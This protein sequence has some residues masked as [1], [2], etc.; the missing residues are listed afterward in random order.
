MQTGENQTAQPP[1]NGATWRSRRRGGVSSMHFEL[2]FEEKPMEFL[3]GTRTELAQGQVGH[4]Q[5][6][7]YSAFSTLQNTCQVGRKLQNF[8]GCAQL[9][10][11]GLRARGEGMKRNRPKM[12]SFLLLIG[13]NLRRFQQDQGAARNARRLG[14]GAGCSDGSGGRATCENL[15]H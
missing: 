15:F 8:N 14:D 12:G 2:L 13:K 7:L 3:P 1:R 5:P 6:R 11:F 10:D 4:G 9:D